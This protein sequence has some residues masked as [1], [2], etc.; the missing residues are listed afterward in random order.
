MKEKVKGKKGLRQL[1]FV[2]FVVAYIIH[3]VS[4]CSSLRLSVKNLLCGFSVLL[5][6]FAF[7][8]SNS[9]YKNSYLICYQTCYKIW[10]TF[11][12]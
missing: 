5:C 9:G 8:L 12:I 2:G 7:Y 10:G 11:T 3:C 4:C 6:A 1:R